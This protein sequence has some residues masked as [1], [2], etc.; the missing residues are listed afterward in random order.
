[1]TYISSIYSAWNCHYLTSFSSGTI[2]DLRKQNPIE[3][4]CLPARYVTDHFVCN[5][6][7][8]C[9]SRAICVRPALFN[10]TKLFRFSVGDQVK[11]VL[12]IGYPANV[13][14]FVFVSR[15]VPRFFYLP[16]EFPYH[17]ELF[18]KYLVTFSLALAFLNAVPCHS[19]DGQFILS[20]LF[21]IL[22]LDRRYARRKLLAYKAL[23]FYCTA[24]LISNVILALW[25]F[26][27]LRL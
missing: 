26:V 18:L 24:V 21:D 19:L 10:D 16:Y 9:P 27:R 11:P 8:S 2:P 1:M 15:F 7:L 23:M 3:Y 4:A 14:N 5:N 12:F 22:P 25:K 6:S 17:C 13:L 20:V